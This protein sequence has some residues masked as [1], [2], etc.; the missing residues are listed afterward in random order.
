MVNFDYIGSGGISLISAPK[1]NYNASLDFGVLFTHIAYGSGD[2]DFNL[3]LNIEYSISSGK[4]YWYRVMLYCQE[5]SDS[6]DYCAAVDDVFADLE[7]VNLNPTD[8]SLTHCSR[9][10]MKT[11]PINIRGVAEIAFSQLENISFDNSILEEDYIKRDGACGD[12]QGSMINIKCAQKKPVLVMAVLARDLDDLCRKLRA[13]TLGPRVVNWKICNIVKFT[14]PV[15]ESSGHGVKAELEQQDVS[16][17][18][19]C[20]NY[21]LDFNF[22]NFTNNNL[23][24]NRF[25]FHAFAK[26]VF[27]QEVECKL[28]LFG[29]ANVQYMPSEFRGFLTFYSVPSDVTQSTFTYPEPEDSYLSI[30][31]LQEEKSPD[32]LLIYGNSEFTIQPLVRSFSG[33]IDISGGLLRFVFPIRN[34]NFSLNLSLTSQSKTV[35]SIKKNSY[36]LIT[37]HSEELDWSLT[38]NFSHESFLELQISSFS[39]ILSSYYSYETSGSI[40]LSVDRIEVISGFRYYKGQGSINLSG[41]PSKLGR[42][43]T[44]VGGLSEISGSAENYI[45]YGFKPTGRINVSGEASGV[46]FET[47][48]IN[49]KNNNIYINGEAD[50]NFINLGLL[51]SEA[52]FYSFYSNVELETLEN[53]NNITIDRLQTVSNCG[54]VSGLSISLDHNVANGGVI[55]EFLSRNKSVLNSRVY[56]NYK[57]NTKSWISTQSLFGLSS[58]DFDVNWKFIFDLS[59]TNIIENETYDER[60]LKFN[61]Y[62]RYQTPNSN[63]ITN[64]VVYLDPEKICNNGVLSAVITR[65]FDSDS[66]YALLVDSNPISDSFYRI[67]DGI[68]IFSSEY[69]N[70]ELNYSR[71]RPQYYPTSIFSSPKVSGIWPEFRINFG[72]ASDNLEMRKVILENPIPI[73][74]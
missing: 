5:Q 42:C 73:D 6:Q 58:Q 33:S 66:G 63:S 41:S 30:M 10:R 51:V 15:N 16:N 31:S 48:L 3:D 40:F 38:N 28:S 45:V 57:S 74:L 52:T 23:C 64:M 72:E 34:Y 56:L 35:F 43:S 24:N 25:V 11:K 18:A 69:W 44:S 26:R 1:R 46:V 4:L 20:I 39:E 68:G 49:L 60:Y 47:R 2:P 54:C 29:E 13:P 21:N 32:S 61:F 55:S 67:Y 53:N 59:C 9:I 62:A 12:I 17:I 70:K 22:T 37:I 8:Q 14:T 19:S 27:Y 71:L 36:N 65:S 50:I 7:S